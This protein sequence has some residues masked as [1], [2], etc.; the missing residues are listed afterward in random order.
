MTNHTCELHG[1][2]AHTETYWIFSGIN[3][4]GPPSIHFGRYLDRFERRNG[5]WAIA[6][7]A[8]LSEWHA[9]LGE[10]PLPPGYQALLNGSGTSARD[11]SDSS[12]ERPLVRQRR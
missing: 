4:V 8:C 7:R 9:A 10:L 12:Y 3:K 2:T 11:R 6:S 1:D 5:R